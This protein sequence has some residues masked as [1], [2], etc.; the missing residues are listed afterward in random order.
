MAAPQVLAPGAA[1]PVSPVA[2]PD[3]TVPVLGMPASGMRELVPQP[4][5]PVQT[6]LSLLTA[7]FVLAV[8]S[9]RPRL[10][11]LA[12]TIPARLPRDARSAK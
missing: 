10:V 12:R 3:V 5:V 4:A 6:L 9:P 11:E 8:G 1:Q 2:S 7:Q